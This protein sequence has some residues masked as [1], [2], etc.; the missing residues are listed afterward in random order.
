MVDFNQFKVELIKDSIERINM[1]DEEYFS[2]KYKNYISNSK[3]S[4]INPEQDGSP[5]KFKEG[6]KQEF[7]SSFDLGTAVHGLILEPEKYILSEFRNKPSAKLGLFVDKIYKYRKEGLSIYNSMLLASEEAD[8]YNNK[9]SYKIIR[10]AI[11]KGIEYY[12]GLVNGIKKDELG[13]GVFVLS[14][15]QR[16]DCLECVNSIKN[17]KSIQKLLYYKNEFALVDSEIHNEDALFAEIKVTFPF[18]FDQPTLG[19]HMVKLKI[20]MKADNWIFDGEKLTLNDLKTTGR[21]LTFFKDSTEI[22]E[23]GEIVKVKGS[24]TKYNYYRQMSFYLWILAAYLNKDKIK[25]EA[26]MMVV[27]TVPKYSS[28]VIKVSVSDIKK[29][30]KELKELLCRVAYCEIY[31]YED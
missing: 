26:N 22:N 4:L 15:K 3:L 25:M 29:G 17:N 5:K 1:S 8:Y 6:I 9:L 28:D 21:P 18:N 24:F 14:D 10:S 30:M 16:G 11:Q 12:I 2:E 7:N 27:E 13:R 23:S 19:D 31:G 20:K